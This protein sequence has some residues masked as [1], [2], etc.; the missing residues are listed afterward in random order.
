[1]LG[2]HLVGAA[3][4]FEDVHLRVRIRVVRQQGEEGGVEGRRLVALS[5]LTGDV[6][7]GGGWVAGRPLCRLF[8]HATANL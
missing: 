3:D 2:T 7:P 1:M 6:G 4:Q 5:S 8:H